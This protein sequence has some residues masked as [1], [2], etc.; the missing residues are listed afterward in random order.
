[1][2]SDMIGALDGAM[3]NREKQNDLHAENIEALGG[4]VRRHSPHALDRIRRA[5]IILHRELN[6]LDNGNA[7]TWENITVY[8]LINAWVSTPNGNG[9][10]LLGSN[11]KVKTW[12]QR[13]AEHADQEAQCMRE[14]WAHI[15][16]VECDACGSTTGTRGIPGQTPGTGGGK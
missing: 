14:D 16:G 7:P 8:D 10:S 15:P 9:S 11:P 1:M 2:G 12:R 5:S 4:Y 3:V 13:A 6:K